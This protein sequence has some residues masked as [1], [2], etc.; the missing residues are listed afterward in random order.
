MAAHTLANARLQK[1]LKSLCHVSSACV[2][3]KETF[4]TIKTISFVQLFSF[5]FLQPFIVF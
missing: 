5:S 1:A 3:V 2:R 4:L